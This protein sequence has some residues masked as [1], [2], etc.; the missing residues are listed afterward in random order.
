VSGPGRLVWHSSLLP[1]HS[2]ASLLAGMLTKVRQWPDSF[3]TV[4]FAVALKCSDG[5]RVVHLIKLY[6]MSMRGD[7]LSGFMS[8]PYN[9]QVLPIGLQ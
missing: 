3:H 2:S 9:H 6:N 1:P 5:Q 7:V 4:T 8:R